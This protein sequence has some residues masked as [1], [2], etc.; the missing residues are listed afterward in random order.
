MARIMTGGGRAYK[1]ALMGNDWVG[2]GPSRCR[3]PNR[4]SERGRP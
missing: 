4:T 1:T 3:E 2:Y